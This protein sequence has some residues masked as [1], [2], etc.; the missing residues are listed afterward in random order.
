M[1]KL[2]NSIR[3]SVTVAS[4]LLCATKANSQQLPSQGFFQQSNVSSQYILNQTVFQRT[5]PELT[6][7]GI[8][9]GSFVVSPTLGV[10]Q[11][12][13]DNIFSTD[14]NEQEDYITLISPSMVANSDWNSHS[15]SLYAR[16]DFAVYD[17]NDSENYDDYIVGARGRLDISNGTFLSSGLSYARNHEDR[18]A[19]DNNFNSDGPNIFKNINADINFN[20]SVSKITLA[21]DNRFARFDFEDGLTSSITPVVVDNDFRDRNE[22]YSSLRLGYELSPNYQAFISAGYNKRIY[23]EEATNRDSDGYEIVAGAAFD[24]TGKL[25]GEFFAG[26]LEQDYENNSLVDI[27]GSSYGANLLWNPTGLTSVQLGV[28]RQ[29]QETTL[30]DFSGTLTTSYNLNVE[31]E[32]LRSLLVGFNA[33]YTSIDFEPISSNQRNDDIYLF[34]TEA[35]YFV[36][37]NLSLNLN[38]TLQQRDSSEIG[39]DFTRNRVTFG[40]SVGL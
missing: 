24:F 14:Q 39:Q 5:R 30:L 20:R 25:K 21:F 8:R 32:L 1:S 16:G 33:G 40:V 26:F 28:V 34:A 38:Y 4:L 37:K 22:Y 23:D 27:S 17:E 11:R 12:F 7:N 10:S 36:N 19:P 29:V 15:L 18:G 9:A 13:D 3:Y 35:R 31:H 2:N 6:P